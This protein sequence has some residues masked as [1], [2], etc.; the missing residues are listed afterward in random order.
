MS[1]YFIQILN[2]SI[3]ATY[4]AIIV[5]LARLFL[6]KS[7]K[8]FS[9]L[10]WLIVLFRLVCPFSIESSLS[11][12]PDNSEVISYNNTLS[13]SEGSVN[14]VETNYSDFSPSFLSPDSN[15]EDNNS[16]IVIKVLS[17]IWALSYNFLIYGVLSC[18]N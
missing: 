2:M 13:Q 3:T 16:G 12:I 10:L 6:K 8:I 15:R 18:E 5:M 1:N 11:L 7:P 17:V 4:V 9:Y 14:D